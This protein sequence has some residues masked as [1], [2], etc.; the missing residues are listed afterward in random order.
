MSGQAIAERIA[1]DG[2]VPSSDPDVAVIYE[3]LDE[4]YAQVATHLSEAQSAAW[5]RVAHEMSTWYQEGFPSWSVKE[6]QLVGWLDP[7]IVVRDSDDATFPSHHTQQEMAAYAASTIEDFD[8]HEQHSL[9]L[10]VFLHSHWNG[11]L[12]EITSNGRHRAAI[13][14]ATGI[15]LVQCQISMPRGALRRFIPAVWTDREDQLMRWLSDQGLISRY[16][17]P[18]HI[19]DPRW[20]G[21]TYAAPPGSPVPWLLVDGQRSPEQIPPRIQALEQ[22]LGPIHDARLDPLRTDLEIRRITDTTPRAP[23]TFTRIFQ[24]TSPP[25]QPRADPTRGISSQQIPPM[26]LD[27]LLDSYA[28][29]TARW[30]ATSGTPLPHPGDPFGKVLAWLWSSRR[31]EGAV[32]MVDNLY[33]QLEEAPGPEWDIPFTWEGL[34][35]GIALSLPGSLEDSARDDLLAELRARTPAAL[36][37]S[38]RYRGDE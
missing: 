14:R 27:V 22:S 28:D 36:I 11:H 19:D 17:H 38:H 21:C 5:H 13:F 23:R 29:H 35:Q 30:M 3:I 25:P 6:T 33:R 16:T 34:L 10:H 1:A 15:P 9:D 8:T 26:L 24:A 20:G 12:A 18:D 2:Y 4:H 31:E 37:P 32:E 7:Q